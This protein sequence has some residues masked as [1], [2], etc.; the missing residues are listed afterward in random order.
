[1]STA[2]VCRGPTPVVSRPVLR[3]TRSAAYRRLVVEVE[4]PGEIRHAMLQTRPCFLCNTLRTL[5]E[6]GFLHHDRGLETRDRRLWCRG[7]TEGSFRA[8]YLTL[9]EK[10][11][12]K[13][14]FVFAKMLTG[15]H[16]VDF[17]LDVLTSTITL[18]LSGFYGSSSKIPT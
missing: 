16:F 10:I 2:L 4:L 5:A 13:F 6:R 15:I 7:R 8:T 9:F 18:V 17:G 1:M 14:C 11:L 12:K 3:Q